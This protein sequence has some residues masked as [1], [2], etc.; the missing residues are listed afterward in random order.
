MSRLAVTS[1][2]LS[3]FGGIR[4]A[5]PVELPS[6][7][8]VVLEGPNESGKSTLMEA[9]A[10]LLAGHNSSNDV[11]ARMGREKDVLDARIE[12]TL[13][14]AL[15]SVES[16]FKILKRKVNRDDVAVTVGGQRSTIEAFQQRI[17]LIDTS[18]FHSVFR[19]EGADGHRGDAVEHVIATAGAGVFTGP[20]PRGGA[21]HLKEFAKG[22]GKRNAGGVDSVAKRVGKIK[23]LRE[24]LAAKSQR[25]AEYES[26]REDESVN[27]GHSRELDGERRELLARQSALGQAEDAITKRIGA[28]DLRDTAAALPEVPA[29]WVPVVADLDELRHLTERLAEEGPSHQKKVTAGD[30]AAARRGCGVDALARL[31]LP[32]ELT[33]QVMELAESATTAHHEVARLSRAVDDADEQIRAHS[34]DVDLK[35]RLLGAAASRP[36][37]D[38]TTAELDRESSLLS[39]TA[40]VHSAQRAFD[41][42]SERVLR[43]DHALH[44]AQASAAGEQSK[45]DALGSSCDV[46]AVVAGRAVATT[47]DSG[48]GPGR[49][50]WIAPASL[51]VLAGVLVATQQYV[52]A[53]V[54]MAL[55]ILVAMVMRRDSMASRASSSAGVSDLVRDAAMAVRD[56]RNTMMQRQLDLDSARRDLETNRDAWTANA[57]ALA[58]ALGAAG[59]PAD[60]PFTEVETMLQRWKAAASA[61]DGQRRVDAERARRSDELTHAQKA[62]DAA[63]AALTEAL[64]PLGI[65]PGSGPQVGTALAELR[66]DVRAASEAVVA[67]DSL[68]ELRGRL[69]DL[70]HPVDLDADDARSALHTAKQHAD[71]LEERKSLEQRA[72]ELERAVAQSVERSVPVRDLVE[73]NPDPAQLKQY[74]QDVAI[75]IARLD[76]RIREADESAADAR[77][78]MEHL[79]S[80]DEITAIEEQISEHDAAAYELAIESVAAAI[81][82]S[83]AVEEIAKEEDER[84]PA[85][86][87][88]TSALA[89]SVAAD[90]RTVRAERPESGGSGFTLEVHRVDGG[91]VPAHQLSTGARMLLYLSLRIAVADDRTAGGIA[92]PLLCDDPL[93]NIDAD[94]A[95]EV[96]RVLADAAEDR[97]VIVT[98]CHRSTSDLARRFG[99]TVVSLGDVN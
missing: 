84:Q 16:K 75:E 92:L 32:D 1:V 55:T 14:D 12:G 76:E 15:F 82:H 29:E 27:S 62:A 22:T 79:S 78:T 72:A 19:I 30:D 81:A 95:T 59:L 85:L 23:S 60:T 5:L 24:E 87:S 91:I 11:V 41:E 98:T 49:L 3:T 8:L 35:I 20:D 48:A 58:A 94:R 28:A 43:A 10:W 61:V 74:E 51:V 65:T 68:D 99:G 52:A 46:D 4:R 86:I 89:T 80:V 17:G 66:N 64:A 70:L 34:S 13:G 96:M 31:V 56:A 39:A 7:R 97:Q 73:Q 37:F 67:R 21:Q 36:G 53:A 93:V 44:D 40:Q 57:V 83:L 50:W 6:D 54:A 2:T 77:K 18:V 9:I 47:V 42:A 90:W 63:D 25:I 45:F 88:R 26:A 38:P 71:T 69:N 33:T